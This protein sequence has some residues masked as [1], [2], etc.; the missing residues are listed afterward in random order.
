MAIICVHLILDS[1]FT[2]ARWLL[3]VIVSSSLWTGLDSLIEHLSY[4]SVMGKY[5]SS[6]SSNSS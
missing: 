4:I 5:L 6:C 2:Y 3:P 1:S